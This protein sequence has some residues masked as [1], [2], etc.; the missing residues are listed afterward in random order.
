[1]YLKGEKPRPR[2]AS[3]VWKKKLMRFVVAVCLVGGFTC[4]LWPHL[5]REQV[6]MQDPVSNITV[7]SGVHCEPD[8]D[9]LRRL[10]IKKLS[11]YVKRE[12]VA[13]PTSETLPIRQHLDNPLFEPIESPNPIS[14]PQSQDGCL[15]PQPVSLQ[16]PKPP[17]K[18]D[19]SHIDFGV[20]TTLGRLND[21]IDAF[22]HWA[23]YTQTRIFALIESDKKERI[24]EV[25]M[26]ADAMGINLFVTESNEEY[27]RRYF[28]LVSH[29]AQNMQRKTQWSVVIDDDTFFLSMT[30]L[31]KA[32]GEYDA[33]QPMYVG[34]LSE[35]IPQVGNFGL[36]GFGGAGVFMSRPLIQ[37]ISEPVIY[38]DCINTPHTGDRKISLCI[39][40]NT[41]TRLTI[42]H[43]LHQ[44]DMTDD[45]SGF[46][47]ANRPPPLSV[48]HWKSWFH[49]D[50]AKLSV[51][52]ELCGDDCL[53]RQFKF[54]DGWVLTNGFSVV[55]YSMDIDPNDPSM[56]LTWGGPVEQYLHE[57]G[58]LRLKDNDKF[59]Y[60]MVDAVLD[61]DTVR[62]YYV[63][64]NA[65]KGD[66]LLELI[67][68]A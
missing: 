4:L 43:R 38:N 55:K 53:L 64:R 67:W 34:G 45:V 18:V 44:L 42:N 13:T 60:S 54:G 59:S 61:G 23:G 51:V 3:W 12:I 10:D 57:L 41:P 26:K 47:E 11:G 15:I 2:G 58:P 33:R 24:K 46:F 40:Q 35:S 22:S 32:L 9:L 14:T 19:A 66:Q 62:Q 1:M 25:Q 56:E 6:V 16:V 63:H 65:E 68:R 48:H 52:G 29:L 31:V 36:M 27:Q 50:M 5:G 8:F 30:E 20:A 17:L 7:T 37:Q 49:A 28:S 21:S 39:Y